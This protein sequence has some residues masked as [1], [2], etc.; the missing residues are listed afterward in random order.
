M[1]QGSQEINGVPIIYTN[2]QEYKTGALSVLCAL[3]PVINFSICL[4]YL[5]GPLAPQPSSLLYC[6]LAKHWLSGCAT[7]DHVHHEIA[8]FWAQHQGRK[9]RTEE[10][11]RTEGCVSLL[12]QYRC[13]VPPMSHFLPCLPGRCSAVSLGRKMWLQGCLIQLGPRIHGE[14][15]SNG[16]MN[17][18][19][20]S[21]QQ[22]LKSSRLALSY[23]CRYYVCLSFC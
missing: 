16:E 14:N 3:W 12:V 19:S 4:S 13:T 5:M 7:W 9:V 22:Q 11:S 23:G 1:L 2:M 21:A 17:C 10:E 15:G 6:S 20:I 8:R 18:S